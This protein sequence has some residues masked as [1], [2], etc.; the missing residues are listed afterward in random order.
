MLAII[1]AATLYATTE[2]DGCT[3]SSI[4]PVDSARDATC[5][6]ACATDSDIHNA[7]AA[8]RKAWVEL[9]E[10]LALPILKPMAEGRLHEQLNDEKGTLEI[11]PSWDGR[12]KEVTYM[13]AFARLMAGLAPW[14]ALPDDET[15]EGVSRAEIR[16]L[17][18][19]AYA[20]AVDP[21]S[22]DYLGWTAAG[23][24]LVDAAYLVESFFRA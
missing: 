16:S 7:G 17:A 14:L 10:R 9:A 19:K 11:S 1:L 20:N 24:T 5:F 12:S 23:Q 13:E 18:L 22:P 6:Y 15:P 2:K 21:E 4:A 3:T 8:T